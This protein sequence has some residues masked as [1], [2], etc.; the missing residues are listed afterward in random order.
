VALA[1]SSQLG[2]PIVFAGLGE[3]ADD[4][5]PFDAQA[6]VDGLLAADEESIP[7]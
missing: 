7:A 4:I 1:V 6:Y 2:L 3:G 5:A